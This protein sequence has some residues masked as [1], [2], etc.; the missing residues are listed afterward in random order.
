M[1]RLLQESHG[2][3]DFGCT[4]EIRFI[5]EYLDLGIHFTE[6]THTYAWTHKHTHTHTLRTRRYSYTVHTTRVCLAAYKWNLLTW[7]NKV[8]SESFLHDSFL[9]SLP[10]E[11]F[12]KQRKFAQSYT[13]C[14]GATNRY[15]Q[16]F[17]SMKRTWRKANTK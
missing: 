4:Y 16:A 13:C 10:I 7:K 1:I 6:W 12:S 17:S 14:F 15:E 2:S 9:K 11:H 8:I 5:K 3:N